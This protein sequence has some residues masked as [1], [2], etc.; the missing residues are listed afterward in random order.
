LSFDREMLRYC[1]QTLRVQARVNQIIDEKT[2]RMI[3]IRRDA[4]ILEGSVCTAECS[5]GRWFCPREIP[6]YW[7]ESWLKRV[8]SPL[9]AA[10]DAS[11]LPLPM[12]AETAPAEPVLRIEMRNAS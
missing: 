11:G 2:G 12:L 6:A 7:R 1:G 5:P 10:S 4:I 3:H 9:P 8:E